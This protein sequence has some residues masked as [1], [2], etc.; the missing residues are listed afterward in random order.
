[1]GFKPVCQTQG[2]SLNSLSATTTTTTTTTCHPTLQPANQFFT[3]T[4]K[5]LRKYVR[6]LQMCT[7]VD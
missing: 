1:M 5:T 2:H 3:F 6:M 4:L 7:A